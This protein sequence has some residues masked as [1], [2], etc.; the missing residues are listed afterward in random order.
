M[1]LSHVIRF[2]RRWEKKDDGGSKKA[3]DYYYCSFPLFQMEWNE[4]ELQ[5]TC[6]WGEAPAF[7]SP[8]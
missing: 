7:V 6:V 2:Q 4:M 5:F 3:I 8:P 1:Y